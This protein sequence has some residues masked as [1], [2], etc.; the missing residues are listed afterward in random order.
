MKKMLWILLAVT[1]IA[2]AGCKTVTQ[3]DVVI[4]PEER[5][6]TV[7]AGTKVHIWL[8][9]KDMGEIAFP[10]DMKLV[11]EVILVRQEQKLNDTALEKTKSDAQKNK[12]IAILGSLVAAFGGIT[13]IMAAFKAGQ[14]KKP[15]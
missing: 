12:W 15:A 14:T 13:G 7:Q 9:K 1:L 8:D 5:I 3:K 6:F 11:N 2:T 4:L 10:T